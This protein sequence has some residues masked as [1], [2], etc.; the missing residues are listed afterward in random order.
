MNKVYHKLECNVSPGDFDE[1]LNYH[2]W[3]HRIQ[4]RK[5]FFTQGYLSDYYWQISHFPTDLRGK[6]VLD[7]GSNDG[8]NSFHCER[9]GAA[10]VLGIDL[11]VDGLGTANNTTGWNARGCEIAK[12]YLDSSVEFRSMS[13]FDIKTLE[14]Q[15]DV[16]ILADVMNWMTDIPT[17]IER[18]SSVCGERLIIRDGLMRKRE[19]TPYLHYV[20][21][22]SMDLMFLPN[23]AFME[24][25]LKQHGFKRVTIKEI[26][27][28]KLYDEWVSNYPLLTSTTQISTYLN[29][30]SS[31]PLSEVKLNQ[32]QALSKVGERAFARGLGWVNVKE[33]EADVFKPRA[34]LGM[35]RK[36]F[37]T[38]ATLWLKSRLN[39][40]VDV[41]YTIIAER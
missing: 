39:R 36:V 20:H 18:V 21:S 8:I 25:I 5:G 11:Y 3:R 2:R 29:P 19:D 13:L 26:S 41:S 10:S 33:V 16:V 22:P 1:V 14:R 7:V 9:I 17:V 4:I 32:V 28:D 35:A 12:K 15:F 31:D 23:A 34:F 27:I 38:D 24:V 37:G 40:T 6:T 30:W